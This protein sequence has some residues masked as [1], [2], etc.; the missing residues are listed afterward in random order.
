MGEKK[1]YVN[2]P[3]EREVEIK[4]KVTETGSPGSSDDQTSYL[5]FKPGKNMDLK[6]L[7]LDRRA[8]GFGADPPDPIAETVKD[9]EVTA[10]A[11]L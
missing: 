4:F 6:Y 8:A 1:Q 5:F 11:R 10:R 7:A 3:G 9:K 2:L